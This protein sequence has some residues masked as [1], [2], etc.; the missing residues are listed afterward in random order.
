MHV[1]YPREPARTYNTPQSVLLE[2]TPSGIPIIITAEDA[3]SA[4]LF[5]DVHVE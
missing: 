1:W 4:Y 3:H 5:P 2:L